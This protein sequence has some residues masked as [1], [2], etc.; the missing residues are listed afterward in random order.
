MR[1]TGEH[2]EAVRDYDIALD[3][4]RRRLADDVAMLHTYSV[5][6][7]IGPRFAGRRLVR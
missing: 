4:V 5:R 6:V 7:V 2:L 1:D 3:V